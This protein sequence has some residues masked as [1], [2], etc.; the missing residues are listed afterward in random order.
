MLRFA[1][2]LQ[3]VQAV[4]NPV[5]RLYWLAA[6]AV[7]VIRITVFIDNLDM[8]RFKVMTFYSTFVATSTPFLAITNDFAPDRNNEPPKL[9]GFP[10]P[11]YNALY[12]STF[13]SSRFLG[14]RDH[15]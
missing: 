2:G 9:M 10:Y 11:R 7:Q 6:R 13:P 14:I 5:C 8:C 4:R 15:L 12:F 3:A 1:L